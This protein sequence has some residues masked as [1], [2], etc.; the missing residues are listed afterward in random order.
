MSIFNTQ[1]LAKL[2]LFAGLTI[3]SQL[4][5]AQTN[6]TIPTTQL[7]EVMV[8]AQKET[9]DLQ[10]VPFA[11]TN[12]D[13]KKV[14]E[15]NLWQTKD[16]RGYIPN[17]YSSNPGDNRNVISIRGIT[18]T[19]Y[20]PAVATYV[21]GVNQFGL[22]T[23]FFLLNDVERIEVLRGPQG[24]LY[25]RNAM[26]GVMNII[27]KPK[28]DETTGFLRADFGNYGFSRFAVGLKTSA[29]SDKLHIGFSYLSDKLDG[30]Y[31]NLFD[32]SD[33]DKQK[34]TL[35][36][37]NISYL[38]A[39]KW[40]AIL[41]T[42]TNSGRNNG[43]FSLAPDPDSAIENPFEVNQ[44]A[45]TE[46]VDD[47]QN[48]SL[49]IKNT[50][51]KFNFSSQ[52][53]FQKNYRY[54]KTPIDGDFS[55]I[56]GVSIVND[57]GKDWN[58]VSVWTQEFRLASANTGKKLN[59]QVGF[60]G[61]TSDAPTKQGIYFGDDA[62]LVGS[63]ISNFTTIN[64]NIAS[65]YGFAFFGQATYSLTDKLKLTA[66]LRSDYEKKELTVSQELD[67]GQGDPMVTQPDTTGNVDY[68]AI[69]PK[70][71]LAYQLANTNEIYG[72]YSR[73]FRPG[74]LTQ[75]G[76]DPSNP[77]L[78][79]YEPEFSNNFEIGSKNYFFNRRMRVN[80]AAFITT[81]S[82]VQVPGLI[83]PDALVVTQNAGDLTSSGIEWE[84]NA[85][86]TNN[87][88]IDWSFGYTNATFDKLILPGESGEVDFS[89]NRQIFTPEFTSMV[90][91]QWT[92]Q[93]FNSSELTWM[94]R[95]EW[96]YFGEQFFNLE[97]TI[98]QD[99]YQIANAK[100]GVV[101]DTM[102]LTFWAKN[103]FDETYIDYAYNF[104]PS[105]LGN[106]ATFGM[107]AMYKF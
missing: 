45:T 50:G 51:P 33:F 55:P 78:F 94:V 39:K 64:T 9:E 56:D 100:L 82:D 85:I 81:I 21:D 16:L 23:Y 41:N 84:I 43:P 57:Y 62:A 83:L 14:E 65:G 103:I 98:S 12:I 18:T 69:S 3:A 47:S 24:T 26:G 59:W 99:A 66:G 67:F 34:N 104:G 88:S 63:P 37:A 36:S 22:D 72:S 17:L 40:E 107:T 35:I 75:I 48:I 70:L 92:P 96:L 86:P 8:T 20:E 91:A 4:S 93:F 11:V 101:S 80:V 44:N 89:G 10:K 76:S 2:S 42:K 25:G 74:G 105:H 97:N 61:F 32:D 29:F 28:S 31:T 46:M 13:D 77:P 68:N 102:E 27:T 6:D 106:P 71:A 52:T 58:T 60:F 79:A 5:L 1:K 49:V 15:M 87:L 19:S 53:A 95:G 90:A 7:G 54:Y 30:F 73:G 38:F